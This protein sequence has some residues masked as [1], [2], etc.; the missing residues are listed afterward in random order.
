MFKV[1]CSGNTTD[2]GNVRYQ[3]K[4]P[5]GDGATHVILEPLAF[6][7]HIALRHPAGVLRRTNRQSCRFV[8]ARLA[9]LVPRPRVNQTRPHGVFAP[10]ANTARARHR[11]G[12]AKTTRP[13]RPMRR[14]IERPPDAWRRWTGRGAWNAFSTSILNLR[15]RLVKHDQ[16]TYP[17]FEK[18]FSA[19]EYRIG[20]K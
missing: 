11:T 9:A 15:M 7:S 16:F 2:G 13:G 17:A 3:L 4:T 10:T 6:M 18:P 19:F 20:G 1:A 14:R 5:C 8:V 12:G